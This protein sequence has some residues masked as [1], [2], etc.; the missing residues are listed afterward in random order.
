MRVLGQ[1]SVAVEE[2]E[3]MNRMLSYTN[4]VR[5]IRR[6]GTWSGGD[7]T[8]TLPL[9]LEPSIHD[10]VAVVMQSGDFGQALAAILLKP[11]S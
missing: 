1:A 5:D 8:L 10:G 4:I 9:A 6:A 3:N 2:G 11:A 7:K